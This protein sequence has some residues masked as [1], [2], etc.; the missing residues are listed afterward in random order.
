MKEGCG[1]SEGIRFGA[2]TWSRL[3][4]ELLTEQSEQ[5]TLCEQCDKFNLWKSSNTANTCSLDLDDFQQLESYNC[6]SEIALD[7]KMLT[8]N[9]KKK[10]STQ[11]LVTKS[12]WY[13]NDDGRF[14]MLVAE[15]LCLRLFECKINKLEG[16]LKFSIPLFLEIPIWPYL[17]LMGKIKWSSLSGYSEKTQILSQTI[18]ILLSLNLTN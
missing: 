13:L 9:D 17:T 16:D 4:T 15:S 11:M 7:G 1:S 8:N 14:E 18:M 10:L 3:N 12:Y 2:A 6:Y 5:F